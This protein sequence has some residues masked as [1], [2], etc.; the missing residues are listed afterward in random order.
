MQKRGKINFTS[1]VMNDNWVSN[2]NKKQKG[3]KSMIE[4]VP[5]WKKMQGKREQ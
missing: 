4:K 5:E 2:S 3:R 1:I